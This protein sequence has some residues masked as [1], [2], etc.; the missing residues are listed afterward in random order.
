MAD[1]YIVVD[2]DRNIYYFDKKG[3]YDFANEVGE[4]DE[5]KI[6]YVFLESF[7]LPNDEACMDVED[8]EPEDEDEEV[9]RD[10]EGHPYGQFCPFTGDLWPDNALLALKNKTIFVPGKTEVTKVV[11]EYGEPARVRPPR[12]R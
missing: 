10:A 11:E 2:S 6:G 1:T 12:K 3:F 8:G 4:K 5:D 7:P 9:E